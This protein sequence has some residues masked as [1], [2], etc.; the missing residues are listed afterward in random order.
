LGKPTS[1]IADATAART[2]CVQIFL[3]PFRWLV[4]PIVGHLTLLD[5]RVLVARVVVARHRH[6]GPIED[7]PAQRNM[8]PPG[9]MTVELAK[10]HLLLTRLAPRASR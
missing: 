9:Q 2:T 6:D 8:A 10:Q 1:S 7:L 4:G 3:L 5:G